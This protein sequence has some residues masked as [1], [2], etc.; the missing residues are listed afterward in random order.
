MITI[1]QYLRPTKESLAVAE[2]LSDEA[3]A[4]YG[5]EARARGFKMAASG[6]HVRSSYMADLVF[7]ETDRRE[8]L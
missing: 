1:G 3:F 7:E 5:R 2:F 8:H 6:T 4:G